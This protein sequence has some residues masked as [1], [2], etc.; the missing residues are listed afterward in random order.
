MQ[1]SCDQT[2]PYTIPNRLVAYNTWGALPPAAHI[3]V[4]AQPESCGLRSFAPPVRGFFA[5][6]PALRGEGGWLPR[7]MTIG[8]MR[9]SHT[10]SGRLLLPGSDLS[11]AAYSLAARLYTYCLVLFCE[12]VSSL[13]NKTATT[14]YTVQ[15][16]SRRR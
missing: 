12:K 7:S 2:P 11:A 14:A 1:A 5:I 9:Q 13:E 8:V 6:C 16:E 15:D 10:A 4:H 3:C